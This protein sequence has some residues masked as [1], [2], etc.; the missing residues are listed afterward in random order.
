MTILHPER[1]E[2]H[3]RIAAELRTQRKTLVLAVIAIFA[4]TL[5]A[6]LPA[7]VSLAQ[8]GLDWGLVSNAIWKGIKADPLHGVLNWV[9]LLVVAGNF[10]YFWRIQL[11][12]RLVL[13]RSG[14]EFHSPM[15]MWVPWVPKSWKLDWG[16]VS[17]VTLRAELGGAPAPQMAVME[18]DARGRK[19]HLYPYRWIESTQDHPVFSWGLTWQG[20]R[21]SP[22][23]MRALVD[24][25]PL[26]R[27]AVAALPQLRVQRPSEL[28][29]AAFAIEKNRVALG[30]TIA[31]FALC[32]YALLDGL[33][34]GS[35]TYAGEPPKE[36]LAVI[37]TGVMVLA[38][39]WMRR[40]RVPLAESIVIAVLAGGAAGAA[41]YPAM[42]RLNA[43]T[44]TEG[45]KSYEYELAAG[46][47]L[48]PRTE[49]L[50]V[51]RFPK[52]SDY[53]AQ[54]QK[55]SV[56][57]FELR[58]GGLGFYQLNLVPIQQELKSFYTKQAR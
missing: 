28:L 32:G 33:F 18:I 47:E 46:A 21:L 53:W 13:T 44:D 36:V 55:G 57:R 51:L 17:A 22:E 42:L 45:L 37:G 54:Q 1:L 39:L 35:E 14:I 20:R 29:Q 34:I 5:I 15:P 11:R 16:Q 43:L 30:I 7:F 40:S 50:P 38:A 23:A 49:G 26:L 52:Y 25:N 27:Y 48:R 2:L 56:H 4:I 9:A 58:Q 19:H 10:I 3:P 12:E 24:D 8:H 31:F 6:L 41:A